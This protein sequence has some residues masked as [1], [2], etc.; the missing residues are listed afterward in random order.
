MGISR[1][2]NSIVTFSTQVGCDI[3]RQPSWHS[4]WLDVKHDRALSYPGLAPFCG[5]AVTDGLKLQLI[6]S[7]IIST[8][9]A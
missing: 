3:Q 4:R 5:I 8:Q 9:I 7:G 1:P 6:S 2:I